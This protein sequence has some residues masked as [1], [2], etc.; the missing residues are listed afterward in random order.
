MLRKIKYLLLLIILILPAMVISCSDSS[1]KG[2]LSYH[3]LAIG[4]GNFSYVKQGQKAI[5]LDAGIGLTQ[6]NRPNSLELEKGPQPRRNWGS[7]SKKSYKWIKDTMTGHGV[8][9]IEAIFISHAHSDH[10][11]QLMNLANDAD[12]NVKNVILPLHY[13]NAE[14]QLLNLKNFKGKVDTKFSKSYKFLGIKF[15]N[16]TAYA[17]R[18]DLIHQS[19]TDPNAESMVIRFAVNG[20]WFL[21]TGDI[22]YEDPKFL[23]KIG[24]QKIDVYV[25]PHHG[26][27]SINNKIVQLIG[28]EQDAVFV[29]GTGSE[30]WRDFSGGNDY[31]PRERALYDYIRGRKAEKQV[32]ITGEP[33]YDLEMTPTYDM[34][35]MPWI[36]GLNSSYEYRMT[37][38]K[39]KKL[40]AETITHK[41]TILEMYQ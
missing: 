7:A 1:Y 41:S 11:N 34:D 5:L 10:F 22:T 39:D 40:V 9:E 16:L 30:E 18:E 4:N 32:F 8:K 14:K 35:F 29:S 36:G 3:T 17:N 26:G 2:N 25:I 38:G 28:K 37:I 23:K 21:F 31:F 6:Q 19:S 13:G 15:E 33:P 20:K 12:F 24:E 27:N